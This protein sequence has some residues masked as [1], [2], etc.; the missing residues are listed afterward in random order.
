MLFGHELPGGAIKVQ[1]FDRLVGVVVA[2]P[3]GLFAEICRVFVEIALRSLLYL[4][5]FVFF[6][7]FLDMLDGLF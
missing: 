1:F 3:W 5:I 2:C 6:K 7:E 4:Y